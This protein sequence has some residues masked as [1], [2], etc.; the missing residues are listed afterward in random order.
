MGIMQPF[1]GFI[2]N[3]TLSTRLPDQF[4]TQ[5]LPTIDDLVELKITLYA[6]WFIQK[7]GDEVNPIT[8]KDLLSDS[9][10][11][12]GFGD[13]LTEIK[14]QF[15]EGLEKAL[16]RGSLITNDS[17]NDI[18]N[19]RFFINSPRGRK[20]MAAISEPITSI[21]K[22]KTITDKDEKLNIFHLYEENFGTLTPMIAESLRDAENKF[23][24]QWIREAMHIAVKN[25]VRRW[26][27]VEAILN[28]WQE[29]GHHGADKKD[30]GEDIIRY[31]KERFGKS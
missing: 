6:L 23:P 10:F 18:E 25:N 20:A 11:V 9:Q 3:E 28:G 12:S 27:Y 31:A 5:L 19:A 15:I 30:P 4:V 17:G 21:E 1:M 7:S 8:L 14:Q 22:K 24:P 16:K 29:E 26:R 2:D 13:N